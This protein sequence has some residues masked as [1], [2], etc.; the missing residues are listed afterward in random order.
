MKYHV[1]VNII[2]VRWSS[3]DRRSKSRSL[4]LACC[5]L[6]WDFFP[7]VTTACVVTEGRANIK[8]EKRSKFLRNVGTYAVPTEG[9]IQKCGMRYD[10]L[11]KCLGSHYKNMTDIRGTC[12]I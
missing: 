9:D 12:S 10:M 3:Y 4:P 8:C 6:N 5:D 1:G 11:P 2:V 7:S